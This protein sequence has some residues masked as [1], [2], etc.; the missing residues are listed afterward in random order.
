ML[1]FIDFE[2]KQCIMFLSY[3]EYYY[4]TVNARA[5]K[6]KLLKSI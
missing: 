6:N 4:W 1:E 2:I 3:E 5:F